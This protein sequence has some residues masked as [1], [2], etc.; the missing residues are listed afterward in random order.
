MLIKAGI[1][2]KKTLRPGCGSEGLC[3]EWPIAGPCPESQESV[4]VALLEACPA[5]WRCAEMHAGKRGRSETAAQ[6][7]GNTSSKQ[8]DGGKETQGTFLKWKNM[9]ARRPVCPDP[10]TKTWIPNPSSQRLGLL[11]TAKVSFL[12]RH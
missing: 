8:P 3:F 4:P 5:G 2:C 9:T 1:M 10:N 7:Q 11:D 12:K 6:I